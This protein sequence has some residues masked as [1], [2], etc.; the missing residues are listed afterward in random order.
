MKLEDIDSDRGIVLV[1]Q[2]KG[3]KDR[4]SILSESVLGLLREYYIK[5]RPRNWLFEGPGGNHYS[6]GSIRKIL[7]KAVKRAGIKKRVTPHT[8][9][10][11]FATHLLEKG[12]DIRWS[13]LL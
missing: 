13:Q 11:S 9:R 7:S 8:L 6:A 1:R 3:R 4:V 5:Y 10:H 2:S 12:T